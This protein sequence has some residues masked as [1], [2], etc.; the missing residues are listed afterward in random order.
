MRNSRTSGAI[1]HIPAGG[2]E[3]QFLK[4]IFCATKGRKDYFSADTAP[5]AGMTGSHDPL[6]KDLRPFFLFL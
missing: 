2:L 4:R 6:K 5:S 3:Q 1:F